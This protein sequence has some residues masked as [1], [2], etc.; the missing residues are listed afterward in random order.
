MALLKRHFCTAAGYPSPINKDVRIWSTFKAQNF[1]FFEKECL[2]IAR[3]TS[4]RGWYAPPKSVSLLLFSKRMIF[5][6]FKLLPWRFGSKRDSIEQILSH[7]QSRSKT[8]FTIYKNW[9]T[10]YHFLSTKKLFSFNRVSN[11]PSS[12]SSFET[13]W[14]IRSPDMCGIRTTGTGIFTCCSRVQNERTMPLH[15]NRKDCI[16]SSTHP[17]NCARGIDTACQACFQNNRACTVHHTCGFI[18]SRDRT[19][20]LP[21]IVGVCMICRNAWNNAMQATCVKSVYHERKL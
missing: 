16:S 6:L 20:P 17:F 14:R 1:S 7:S 2:D 9:N 18:P 4:V 5:F 15:C 21:P 19:D 11:T 13:D 12:I 3:L 8:L 10:P